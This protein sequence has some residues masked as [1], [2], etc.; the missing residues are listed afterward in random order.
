MRD[1]VTRAEN[2]AAP[3]Q[4]Q[5]EYEKKIEA[6]DA[7]IAILREQVKCLKDR[8]F[9][10]KSEKLHDDVASQ[11][12]SLFELD[13]PEDLV[14][15]EPSGETDEPAVAKDCKPRGRKKLP[16]W[17]LREQ[18]IHDLSD[19]EKVCACGCVKIHIGDDCSEVLERV[20]A[21]CF[22]VEHVRRK[23]ACENPDC[24]VAMAGKSTIVIAPPPARMIPKS[25][26]GHS[27]LAQVMAA[28]FVDWL[29]FYRV[30]KQLRR[31]GVVVP[32][33]SMCRWA[34]KVAD[35]FKPLWLLLLEDAKRHP[36][37]QIDETTVQVMNEPGR[38]NTSKSYMWVIRGGPPDRPIVLYKYHPSRA[39]RVAKELLKD[40]K[41]VVQT[42]G[43]EGYSFL[44][45]KETGFIHAGCLAHAR[46]KFAAIVKMAGKNRKSGYADKILEQFRRLYKVESEARDA[47]LNDLLLLEKRRQVSKPIMDA[48]HGLLLEAHGKVPP[49][50]LLGSAVEY[51]LNQW[52]KLL[53][54]LKNGLIKLDTNDVEN[55]IRPFVVGRK[56]WMFSGDPAG[57]EASAVLYSMVETAKAAGWEPYRW[58]RHVF[59]RLPTAHTEDERR[60]LLPNI[61]SED[62]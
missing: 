51:T 20:P 29:P 43:F 5:A 39:G 32:R 49:S 27:L 46:R 9:G 21:Q 36:Y 33:Q 61:P 2:P 44:D 7:E 16:D 40:F 12:P 30:E 55:A 42:D 14:E 28:K 60:A 57:A 23:Y 54:F 3:A 22:V 19:E 1:D 37:L 58:I 45:K 35:K 41:G 47:G 10:R 38:Q 62:A 26:A 56:N 15:D 34:M 24:D 13:A 8:L 4:L 52:P 18:K 17:L 6:R 53:E 50:S 59:D 31:E 48:L 25:L 11:Q